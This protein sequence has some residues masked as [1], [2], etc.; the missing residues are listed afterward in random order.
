[1]DEP[2]ARPGAGQAQIAERSGETWEAIATHEHR[3]D[4]PAPEREI[5]GEKRREQWGERD[6]PAILIQLGQRGAEPEEGAVEENE[7]RNV[8]ER[9]LAQWL[10]PAG[11][12]LEE[13]R[14]K[15]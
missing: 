6:Q 10:P 2:G 8:A 12:A 3:A 9:G 13:K 11:V 14:A 15:Q 5:E 7:T 1:M 4:V